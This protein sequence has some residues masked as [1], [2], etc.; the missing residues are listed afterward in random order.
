MGR[1]EVALR[2]MRVEALRPVARVLDDPEVAL[3]VRQFR[4]VHDRGTLLGE[5]DIENWEADRV[6]ELLLDWGLREAG[7]CA[8]IWLAEVAGVELPG[9]LVAR[10]Y[11]DLWFPSSDDVWIRLGQSDIFIDLSHEEVAQRWQAGI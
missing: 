6:R 1:P 8:V 7:R 4:D 11:D 2:V 10:Y 5:A 9:D 3:G